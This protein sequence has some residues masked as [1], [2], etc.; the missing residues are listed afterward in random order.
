M[1][2]IR[3]GKNHWITL[4]FEKSLGLRE[5][6]ALPGLLRRLPKHMNVTLDF[7]DVRFAR[8]SALA[9]LIPAIASLHRPV[10]VIGLESAED[11]LRSVALMPAAA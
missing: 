6:I 1:K 5:A 9:V 11:E 7:S 10:M 2:L 8:D 3:D 4:Q